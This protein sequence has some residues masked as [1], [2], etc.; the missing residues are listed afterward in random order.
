[1]NRTISRLQHAMNS[2]DAAAVAALYS[3]DY[4]SEQPAHP[5]RDFAGRSQVAA[6]WRGMFRG[7][8]D[9]EAG[10]VKEST[11]GATSWSEWVWRGTR[12]DGELFLMR[13]V[14]VMGLHEDGLIAWSRLYME[15][16]EQAGAP[17]DEAVRQL[18]GAEVT[19][20]S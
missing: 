7:V 11:D 14:I 10:V 19:S 3:A 5:S 17:I 8:P 2:H 4:R 16:V 12:T 15:P 1:M 18:S 9:L 6:N 20:P 13:G